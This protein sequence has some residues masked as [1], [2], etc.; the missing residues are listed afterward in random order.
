[1]ALFGCTAKQ[2]RG[3]NPDAKGN[4]RDEATI[5]QLL[6]LAN[7]ENYNAILIEQG[8]LQSERLVLLR[9]MVV[10]Q[11]QTLTDLSKEALPKLT[12]GDVNNQKND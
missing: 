5:N 4:M 2:W 8:K 6:V 7:M 3:R 11:L 9:K 10:R 1:M 12:G